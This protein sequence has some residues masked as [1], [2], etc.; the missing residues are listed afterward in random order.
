MKTVR[1]ATPISQIS[2]PLSWSAWKQGMLTPVDTIPTAVTRDTMHAAIRD[3]HFVVSG[4]QF[5][6]TR[7]AGQPQPC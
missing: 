7:R 1:F 2:R 5:L 6:S 4:S 3:I